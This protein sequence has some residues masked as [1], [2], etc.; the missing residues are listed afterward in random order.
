MADDPKLAEVQ[1]QI[2]EAKR[3]SREAEEARPFSG[4]LDE[5]EEEPGKA[6]GAMPA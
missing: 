4:G 2:D 3:L 6:D 1:E 5:P